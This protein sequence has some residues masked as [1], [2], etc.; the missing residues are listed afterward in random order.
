M[1]LLQLRSSNR[2]GSCGVISSLKTILLKD[3]DIKFFKRVQEISFL[4]S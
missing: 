1:F 2:N 4:I 3:G